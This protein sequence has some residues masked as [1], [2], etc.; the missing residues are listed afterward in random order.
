LSRVKITGRRRECWRALHLRRYS[1]RAFKSRPARGSPRIDRAIP[2]ALK[3]RLGLVLEKKKLPCEVFV[4]DHIETQLAGN[5]FA[6][7]VL[8]T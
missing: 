3:S 5:Q 4:V 6:V 7:G 1:A 8:E 2:E